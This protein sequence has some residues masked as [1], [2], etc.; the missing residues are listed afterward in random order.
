MARLDD[1]LLAMYSVRLMGFM[2]LDLKTR[3]LGLY[4]ALARCITSFLD[5]SLLIAV[6]FE[7]LVRTTIA[8]CH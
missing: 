1:S 5:P 6:G 8:L 2:L 4:R 7:A 3:E